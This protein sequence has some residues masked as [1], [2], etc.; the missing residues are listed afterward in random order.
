MANITA[1]KDKSGNIISYR[2][3]VHKGRDSHGKQLKPYEMTWKPLPKMTP[4]QIEKELNRQTT[5]FEEKCKLGLVADSNQTFEQYA[6]YVMDLKKRQGIKRKTLERYT[7]LLKRINQGIGHLKLQD[8]K[9]QHLNQLYEQ[10]GQEGIRKNLERAV[11]Y[12]NLKSTLNTMGIT[13][14]CLHVK[15]GISLATIRKACQLEPIMPDKANMIS[16]C[17]GIPLENIFRLE[18]NSVPLSNKTIVEH[19]RLVSTIM[20]QA[21][22]EL[23]IPFN[24]ARK[25]SPPKADKTHANYFEIEEVE[26]IRDAI[27]KEPLKWKTITH[28]LLITGARRAEIVGLKWDDIDFK[29]NQIHISRGLLYSTEIGIY[30]DTTKNTESDRYVKLPNETMELLKQYN[31]WYKSQ[32]KFFGDRWH[33]TSYLFFQDKSGN[34]GKPIHP[35]SVNGWLKRFSKRYDLPHINPHAFRH[36]MASILYF[37]G[38]DS[39][40]ISKRLG[41]AKVSTTTDIYSH[42]LKQADEQSAEC[43]ADAILRPKIKP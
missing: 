13:N 33:N 32:A 40:S 20:A 6:E 35:D 19:H 4:K 27:D 36:T 2:I 7:D 29:S 15:S 31:L 41:H 23:L 30:E 26:K 28:L 11:C 43:I 12:V 22:K 25:A 42:I 39:I 21:D 3:R 17:L 10:L 1:R 8:I 37:S 34:E 38:A 5:L 18:K 14:Q 24:P 16:S 9:P